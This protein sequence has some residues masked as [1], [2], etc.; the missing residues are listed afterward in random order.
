MTTFWTTMLLLTLKRQDFNNIFFLWKTVL[1]MVW[2]WNRNR[3]RNFSKVGT[4]INHFGST[5]LP[6][7]DRCQ[8]AKQIFN[9]SGLT[10]LKRRQGQKDQVWWP[11][12]QRRVHSLPLKWRVIVS[13][14]PWYL[15][16]RLS[17]DF[18]NKVNGTV[19]P[20]YSGLRVVLKRFS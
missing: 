15:L 11:L 18:K 13:C 8:I 19:R 7:L 12:S 2:L 3:H 1:N 16:T 20:D 9:W 17:Q 10:C 5:T 14:Q 6:R 4:G